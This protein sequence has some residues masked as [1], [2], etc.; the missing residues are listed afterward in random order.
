MPIVMEP[1]KNLVNITTYYIEDLKKT[2]NSVFHFIDSPEQM[3]DWKK[4]G[5]FTRVELA[6]IKQA[7]QTIDTSKVIEELHTVWRRLTWKEQNEISS[8]CLIHIPMT[9]G[10]TR[11]QWDGIRFRDLKLKACLKGWDLTN[12]EGRKIPVNDDNI[13]NLVPEVAHQL[14]SD[15]E[16]VTEPSEE[17][18][19]N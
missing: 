11:S 15:F 17:D 3:S 16:R 9:D 18:L 10:Q 2:G 6:E 14:V 19:G 1:S 5:Y 7:G 12:E 8:K 13:D 4:R